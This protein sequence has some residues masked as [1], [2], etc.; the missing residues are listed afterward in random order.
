MVIISL[1]FFGLLC[2]KFFS[3]NLGGTCFAQSFC[4]P[5]W[6]GLALRKVFLPQLGRDLLCAKFFSPNLRGTCFVQSKRTKKFLLATF[7]ARN[8]I[9]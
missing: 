4:P 9:I 6:E 7:I 8:S 3:S 2:A 5:S 1:Y